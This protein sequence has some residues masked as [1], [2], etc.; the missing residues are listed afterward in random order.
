MTIDWECA[1]QL[2]TGTVVFGWH[3][4]H[5]EGDGVWLGKRGGDKEYKIGQVGGYPRSQDFGAG[6]PFAQR[7]LQ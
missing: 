5:S 6:L 1:L 7:P 3:G 4:Q 2:S